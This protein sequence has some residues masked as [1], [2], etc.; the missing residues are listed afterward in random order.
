MLGERRREFITLLVGAAAWPIAARAQQPAMPVVGFLYS[1]GPD[2]AAHIA[3]AFRRGLRDGGFIDGQN[4]K[5][6]YRWAHGRFDRLPAMAQE[7]ARMPLTV[8]VA[9]GGDPVAMAAKAA[10]ST[11]PI[12]FAMG[13]DPI[14]LG[15]AASYNRPGGNATGINVLSVSLEPKRLGLLRDLV[16][17]ATTIG[18][19]V[20]WNFSP[21]PR[22][23]SDAEE[24][25]RATGVR[26]EILRASSE[27]EIDA[28]FETI[29]KARIHALAVAASPFFDTRRGQIVALAA[30]H[31]VPAIYHFREYAYAGGLMSYGVDIVDIYRQVGLYA[32]QIVSGAKPADLPILLP[33]KFELVINLETA[34]ALGLA[35]P[36]GV[37]AIADEVIE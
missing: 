12:V 32:A 3:A 33:T 20:N 34:K 6:E 17:A 25:A 14:K 10:T 29:A 23:I 31:A 9:G 5:V 36:P 24:A 4:V 7:L 35:I 22:Q 30:R 37:L 15:F 21:A 11:I 1:R 16:P 27:R 19:L 2:D 13:G 28:A 26:L 8:L 18:F